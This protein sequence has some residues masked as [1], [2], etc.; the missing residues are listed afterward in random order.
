MKKEHYSPILNIVCFII[1]TL[2]ISAMTFGVIALLECKIS[3]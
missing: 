2:F 3:G 1:L